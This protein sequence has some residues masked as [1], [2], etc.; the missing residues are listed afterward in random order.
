MSHVV[1]LTGMD[2]GYLHV[3]GRDTSKKGDTAHWI[4]RCKC[5]TICSKD[6]R[7]LRNGHAKSCGCFRKERAATLITKKDPAKKPKTEPKKKKFGRGP[8]RA[9]SGICYNPLCP[10]RNNYRGA[11]S[12]TDCRFCPERKFTR[13]SRREVITL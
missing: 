4:C 1:D 2:F 13:Q 10:T 6:G 8:Q 7:Y 5:G 12:C 3:V 11:W 9:G